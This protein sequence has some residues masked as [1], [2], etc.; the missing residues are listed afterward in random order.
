MRRAS[1]SLPATLAAACLAILA[2]SPVVTATDDYDGMVSFF[3]AT[4]GPSWKVNTN[5][6]VGTSPCTWYG[7]TCNAV[8]AVTSLVLPYNG[9]TGTLP[10]SMGKFN[11]ML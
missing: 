6:L 4:N 2:L 7:V 9:L 3:A 5:W 1:R 8:G 11:T 10:A